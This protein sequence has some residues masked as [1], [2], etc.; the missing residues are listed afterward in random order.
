MR[1]PLSR[2]PVPCDG[3]EL[4]VGDRPEPRALIRCRRPRRCGAPF[5]GRVVQDDRCLGQSPPSEYTAAGTHRELKENFIR[6]RS[7]ELNH[8][9]VRGHSVDSAWKAGLAPD[10]SLVVVSVPG[11]GQNAQRQRGN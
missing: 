5:A 2:H 9:S 3:S 8:E 11:T 6:R 10:G 1:R 7:G 4:Y